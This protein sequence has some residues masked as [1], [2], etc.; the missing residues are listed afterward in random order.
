MHYDGSA[1]SLETSNTQNN[2]YGVWGSSSTDVFAVGANATIVHFDG[3]EWSPMNTGT[4]GVFTD[5]YGVWGSSSTNVYA[6]GALGVIVHYD[7]NTWSS[8]SSG[9][10]T[11]YDLHGV[12]GSSATNIFVVGNNGTILNYHPQSPDTTAVTSTLNPSNLGDSVTFTATVTVT[13]PGRGTPTGTVTFFDGTTTSDSVAL[14]SSGPAVYVT[15][16][17]T[18]GSHSI[19]ANYSGDA[20]FQ[21]STSPVLLQ[22]VKGVPAA[23]LSPTSLSFGD[24]AV[25]TTSV[26][27]T[28]TM[29]NTGTATLTIGSITTTANFAI[30]STTCGEALLMGTNCSVSVT[31]TPSALGLVAGTLTFTDDAS[32]SPQTASLAGTGTAVLVTLFP[33]NVTFPKQEIGTTSVLKTFTLTNH[34]PQLTGIAISAMGD[35]AV[36]DTTCTTSLPPNGHCNIDVTFAPA[37]VGLRPGQLIVN[38]SA[39]DSPQTASLDGTGIPGRGVSLAPQK[40]TF[41]AQFVSTTSAAKTFTLINNDRQ[42]ATNIVISTTGD[43][44]VLDMTCTTSLKSNSSCTIDVTFTPTATG[45]R[46]GQLS[47]SDRIGGDSGPSPQAASPQTA[48]LTG[49]GKNAAGTLRPGSAVFAL[50]EI[51]TISNP[52]TVTLTNNGPVLT[53]IVISATGDYTVSDTT[54]TTSLPSNGHCNIDVTFA[55]TAVGV[56]AGQLIVNDSAL[57]SPQ[58]AGLTGT[59]EPGRGVNLTPPKYTFAPQFVSTT[60]P[61]KTFTLV[62]NDREGASNIAI[63]TTGDFA[64]ADTTCTTS[65]APGASCTID[66]TFTPTATGTRTGQLSVSDRIGGDSSPSPQA[67]SPQTAS[68]T[69]T[70]K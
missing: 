42:V 45:T 11:R 27:Q 21:G 60:S 62:N 2:L 29:T 38:D 18:V 66:V 68:L 24:Q 37:E 33:G 22:Q 16:V 6:V 10:D 59:G 13:P 20:N 54:C 51:G 9:D 57:D 48:S 50:Q 1:W 58:T 47:V 46:T 39:S 5:L 28:V 34:G 36:S 40:Y 26:P 64:V 31:F 8:L 61:A 14:P 15:S 4:T 25:G 63:S 35:F 12:W 52:K 69:G 67:A 43:F 17:L 49:T 56:R 23:A 30:S 55:P 19:T 53:N 70:G 44:A 32:N 65:L 3:T 7:G 41:A